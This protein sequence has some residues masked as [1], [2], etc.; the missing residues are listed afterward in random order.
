MPRQFRKHVRLSLAC[1]AVGAFLASCEDDGVSPRYPQPSEGVLE[2]IRAEQVPLLRSTDRLFIEG[3]VEIFSIS[4]GPPYDCPSG[5]AYSF[6]FGVR[7][8]SWIGW[9]S[10]DST[11][12]HG[13]E[14]SRYF[15][16][17]A[18]DSALCHA[19][20]WS[21]MRQSEPRSTWFWPKLLPVLARD[22]DTDPDAL[23][24]IS[25]M[26]A[27]YISTYVA[28]SLLQNE[29]VQRDVG[30][31]TNLARLPVFQGDSYAWTRQRAEELLKELD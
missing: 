13:P 20:M 21:R 29:Y 28:W 2:F 1:L 11:R 7:S 16:V 5:C 10:F 26:L 4:F 23:L 31:L 27:S 18:A 12:V 25:T 17:T 15:D 8:G 3:P 24:R 14:R 19:E 9:L 30:I 22:P 6:A